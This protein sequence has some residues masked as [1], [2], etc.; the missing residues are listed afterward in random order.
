MHGYSKPMS[1]LIGTVSKRRCITQCRGSFSTALRTPLQVL[2]SLKSRTCTSSP[3]LEYAAFTTHSS[4]VF[5][6]PSK[7][8]R[9]WGITNFHM[10]IFVASVGQIR[11]NLLLSLNTAIAGFATRVLVPKN[12]DFHPHRSDNFASHSP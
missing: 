10:L 6:S 11:G 8:S 7:G 12:S 5:Q 1:E 2:A 9:H 4:H 3:V